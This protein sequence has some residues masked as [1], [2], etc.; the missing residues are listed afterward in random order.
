MKAEE[1]NGNCE[2]ARTRTRKMEPIATLAVRHCQDGGARLPYFTPLVHAFSGRGGK[3]EI[4]RTQLCTCQIGQVK[5]CNASTH[6]AGQ[7]A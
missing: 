1:L 6:M 4:R 5:H 2:K 3:K 7:G